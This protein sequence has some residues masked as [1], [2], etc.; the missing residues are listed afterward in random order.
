MG[1][2]SENQQKFSTGKQGI[3]FGTIPEGSVVVSGSLPGKGGVHSI[4]Q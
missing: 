3:F 4:A 2:L 1:V